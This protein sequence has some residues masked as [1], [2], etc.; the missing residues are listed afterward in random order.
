VKAPIVSPRVEHQTACARICNSTSPAV[1]DH[2]PRSTSC[3][4]T[5]TTSFEAALRTEYVSLLIEKRDRREIRLRADSVP[6]EADHRQGRDAYNRSSDRRSRCLMERTNF[7]TPSYHGK[8]E[9]DLQS[10]ILRTPPRPDSEWHLR[11]ERNGGSRF[12]AWQV[13]LSLCK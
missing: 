8:A 4:K 5:R 9:V 2:S 10:L 11:V 7:K 6:L 3:S 1:T 13:G 12:L